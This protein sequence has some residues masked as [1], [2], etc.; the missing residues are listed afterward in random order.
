VLSYASNEAT[1]SSLKVKGVKRVRG[2]RDNDTRSFEEYL[3]YGGERKSSQMRRDRSGARF[4]NSHAVRE[5]VGKVL[6][7]FSPEFQ[8]FYWRFEPY[9]CSLVLPPG[10]SKEE[11]FDGEIEKVIRSSALRYFQEDWPKNRKRPYEWPDQETVILYPRDIEEKRSRNNLPDPRDVWERMESGIS[12]DTREILQDMPLEVKLTPRIMI[13]REVG[14]LSLKQLSDGEQRLF[15]LF[16]DIARELSLQEGSDGSIGGGKAIVLIDEIDVH[17]HPKWQ[18]RIVPALEELFPNCQFIAT[19]HSPFVIQSVRADSKLVLLDGQ[20]LAQLGNTGIE[21]IAHVVMD[22]DRPD[23]GVRYASQVK[24]AKSFLQLLDEAD[25]AP[26][27]KLE[28]YIKRL[29]EKLEHAEN[30]AMQAFLELQLASRL[31]DK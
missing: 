20:S 23:V 27:E 12:A 15:S 2:M 19:T 13:R 17:L 31:G 11:V 16:V 6:S 24:M 25:A 9:D 5:F 21:K 18:R 1:C 10:E 8:D 22:V 29:S 3:F 7:T 28:R 14:P 4:G 26:K 30:P